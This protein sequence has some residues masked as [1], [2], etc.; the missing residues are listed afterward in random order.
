MRNKICNYCIYSKLRL[1]DNEVICEKHN[2][3][4]I[5]WSDKACNSYIPLFEGVD[6]KK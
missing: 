3:K 4:F 6:E 2:N 5:D 1:T